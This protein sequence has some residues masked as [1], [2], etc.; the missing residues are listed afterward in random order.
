M[1]LASLYQLTHEKILQEG[2]DSCDPQLLSKAA[3][4]FGSLSVVEREQMENEFSYYGP[5]SKLMN[6]ESVTEILINGASNIWV[7]R[8][9]VLEKTDLQFLSDE[10]LQRLIRIFLSFSGRKVDKKSPFADA[11][12]PDGSR[13]CVIANPAVN[14][15][16]HIAIRK[17]PKKRFSLEDLRVKHFLSDKA[18]QY[19][20]AAVGARKN[21]FL[22]GGTGSGKTT[23]LNALI[24]LVPAHDRVITLEDISELC[25]GHAHVVRLEGRPPNI[26]GEGE[27]SLRMLLRAAM[28]MRPDRIVVGECRGVEALDVLQALNTGHAGS[29]GTIH[30]NSPRDALSRLELLALLGA[31]NLNPQVLKTYIASAIHIVVQ[32]ERTDKGRK[33]GSI[34]EVK[35]IENGI[36]LLRN[37][38]I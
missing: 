17:F 3:Q 10:S 31:E 29:M 14:G 30:A 2:L 38:E 32:I 13:V 36:F 7:E 20:V 35:G 15:G 33:I 8:G 26:E 25:P 1:Q 12:L 9:G 5:I 11:R 18:F 21:I 34:Q 4:I 37:I 23:L 28:R 24:D 16:A 22:S 27:I 6:D 19:L